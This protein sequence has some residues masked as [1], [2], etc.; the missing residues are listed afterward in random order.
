MEGIYDKA[1][2]IMRKEAKPLE[3]LPCGKGTKFSVED[4][5]VMVDTFFNLYMEMSYY[6][7]ELK[8]GKD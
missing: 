5:V 2:S 3:Q 6:L 7:K 1:I 4:V 8:D